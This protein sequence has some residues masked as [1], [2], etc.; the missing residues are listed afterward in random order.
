MSDAPACIVGSL[1]K[2]TTSQSKQN[3]VA[4]N[5][6]RV[7]LNVLLCWLCLFFT[8]EKKGSG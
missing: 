1:C 5:M 7:I 4:H 6:C 2:L 8:V 3:V